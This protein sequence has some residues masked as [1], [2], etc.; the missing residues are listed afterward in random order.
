[1]QRKLTGMGQLRAPHCAQEVGIESAW[2]S[3]L[4][5]KYGFRSLKAT[6]AEQLCQPEVPRGP[7][8]GDRN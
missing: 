5:T 7:S 8:G 6:E 1:M 3:P 4:H 2:V